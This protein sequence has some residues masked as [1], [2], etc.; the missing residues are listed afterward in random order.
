MQASP[1][2]RWWTILAALLLLVAAASFTP[3]QSQGRIALVIGNGA[4][5]HAPPLRNPVNDARRMT[6]VLRGAGFQV[7][8]G[9]NLT[10]HQM[11]DRVREF[12][13]RL[14]DAD[15]STQR[16]VAR[17]VAAICAAGGRVTLETPENGWSHV[18]H[19]AEDRSQMS[20]I[21]TRKNNSE[22]VLGEARHSD[23]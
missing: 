19:V 10:K 21:L 18:V 11:E 3:A 4:Y 14:D 13:D 22:E 9:L 2:P 12:G 1:S 8:L 17:R 5:Q 15:R 16:S 23:S 20:G 6:E 7:I